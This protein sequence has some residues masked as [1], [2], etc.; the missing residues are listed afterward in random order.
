MKGAFLYL[1]SERMP[2]L[3][4]LEGF[5]EMARLAV[6]GVLKHGG[7]GTRRLVRHHG[8]RSATE[9]QSM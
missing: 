7:R 6:P 1:S 8:A 5:L 4:R 2:L 9:R 3:R